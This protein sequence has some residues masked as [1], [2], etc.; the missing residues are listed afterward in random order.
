MAAGAIGDER[1]RR[2]FRRDREARVVLRQVDL[3][4]EPVGGR[5]RGDAGEGELLRQA[6][7]R[8]PNACSERPRASG[9]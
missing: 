2:L 6:S 9:E 7:C 3:S 4:D 8:V 1:G 5:E